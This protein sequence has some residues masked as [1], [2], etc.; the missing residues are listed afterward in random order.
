MPIP[1]LA[2]YRFQLAKWY[3]ENRRPLPW[4]ATADPYRIWVA[5]V[6]LQQTQVATVIP[7][8]A[9]FLSAFPDIDRLATATETEVLKVWE[10]LGYYSRAR[11]LWQA[12]RIIRERYG[13]RIPDDI[14]LFRQL[15]GVGAYIAAAVMSIAFG[16]PMAVLDGNVRRVLARLCCVGQPVNK[17]AAVRELT[18]LSQQFLDTDSPA[19]YNQAIME[20][21]AL[22]CR[23]RHPRCD[24]C[25]V[26]VFCCAWQN[27]AVDHF[28][29]C[30]RRQPLP[31][32]HCAIGV[33]IRDG[34]LLVTR[35]PSRG[36][37]GG[38]WEFP[39]GK[40]Q[41][42]ESAEAACLRELREE[43]N[44]TVGIVTRLAT[45]RHA[46]THFRVIL[47]VFICRWVSGTII[48]NGSVDYRWLD[49]AQLAGLPFPRANRRFIPQLLDYLGT[50]AAKTE[51][52]G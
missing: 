32:R 10:G 40:I 6:M 43:V 48:L 12:A 5:E 21:G 42:G 49:P 31:T 24:S 1:D 36:L 44:L 9:A 11:A 37:L 41:E 15:P 4:R 16:Q 46:Y 19:D 39:G 3:Q 51:Q 50:R 34:Q 29:L 8:Y 23:P 35:R 45:V 13:S 2:E 38:L 27:Q 7:Y 17:P 47:E 26:A 22:V 33:I 20:L 52:T 30:V 28:P 18:R 25:P 14:T